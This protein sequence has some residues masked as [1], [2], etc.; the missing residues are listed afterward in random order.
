MTEFQYPPFYIHRS[1]VCCVINFRRAILQVQDT[2]AA[3]CLGLNFT[4]IVS[5]DTPSLDTIPLMHFKFGFL[6]ASVPCTGN[7]LFLEEIY[8]KIIILSR[9][10]DHLWWCKKI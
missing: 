1:P 5:V 4:P 9:L 6:C 10:A 7:D 3:D 8:L 2:Y